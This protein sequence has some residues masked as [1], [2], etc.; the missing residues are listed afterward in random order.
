MDSIFMTINSNVLLSY[1]QQEYY[2]L[3]MSKMHNS[4]QI[5]VDDGNKLTSFSSM[6]HRIRVQY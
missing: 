5:L 4:W 3:S 2:Y 1:L 6:A